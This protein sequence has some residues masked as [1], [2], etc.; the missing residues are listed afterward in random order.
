MSSM[1]LVL[2]VHPFKSAPL[3][4]LLWFY[5]L[6]GARHLWVADR[7][8]WDVECIDKH[9]SALLFSFAVSGMLIF[10]IGVK[11]RVY[12]HEG[13]GLMFYVLFGQKS[14]DARGSRRV[15]QVTSVDIVSIKT[16]SSYADSVLG[17]RSRAM[18]SR[19]PFFSLVGSLLDKKRLCLPDLYSRLFHR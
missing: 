13:F 15:T 18:I 9:V 4:G 19:Q 11:E 8:R 5:V 10:V 17:L 16:S 3:T 12:Q 6:T 2:S 1:F 14:C 7:Y